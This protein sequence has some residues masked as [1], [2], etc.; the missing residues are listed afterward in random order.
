MS[1]RLGEHDLD[2]EKEI[3]Q[4]ID[5]LSITKHPKFNRRD[6]TNDIAILQLQNDAEF[7]SEL[8]RLDIE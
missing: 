2:S 4:D 7:S 6:K 1:V 3:V 5:I 8:S